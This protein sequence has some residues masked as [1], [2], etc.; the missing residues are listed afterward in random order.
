VPGYRAEEDYMCV[1]GR[2]PHRRQVEQD[3]LTDASPVEKDAVDDPRRDED[4]G[5]SRRCA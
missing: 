3:R 4:D 5:E 1:R 2:Q